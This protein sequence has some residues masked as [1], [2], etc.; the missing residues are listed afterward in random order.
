M[1]GEGEPGLNGGPNGNLYLEMQ[2]RPHKFFRRQ[3]DTILLDLNINIV[4]ATLGT[5]ISVPTI[6]GEE[7]LTI[8]TGTQPGKV[9]TMRERGVPHLRGN[10]RGDQ[11]VIVNVTIPRKLS[12]EQRHLFESLGETMDTEVVPQ[13]RGFFE[14][15]KDL[16]NG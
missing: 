2:V 15:L 1:S 3:E 14:G 9:F 10:G 4:Q 7:E 8:P 11:K 16:F 6:D 5:R 13:E 12:K